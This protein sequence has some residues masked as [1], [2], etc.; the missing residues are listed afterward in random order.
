[1]IMGVVLNMKEIRISF[2]SLSAEAFPMHNVYNLQKL[3]LRKSSK[4]S[5]QNN[6]KGDHRS[7]CAPHER[8]ENILAHVIS[9]Y[10]FIPPIQL[11]VAGIINPKQKLVDSKLAIR[12]RIVVEVALSKRKI[13][14]T[15]ID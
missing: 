10:A 7:C 9:I 13:I 5:P 12:L 11:S 6:I 8:E 1:M 4:E 14:R 3:L 2:L 15:G